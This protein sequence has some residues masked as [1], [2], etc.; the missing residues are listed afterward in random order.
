[1]LPATMAEAFPARVRVTALAF[2]YNLCWAL[3]GG[4]APLVVTTLTAWS[5][6]AEA[7]AFYLMGAAAI[8]LAVLLPWR[9]TVQV[10]L[11]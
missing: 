6:N 10:P 3:L 5:H 8:S 11:P 2:S 7:P 9:E 4:T 1:V